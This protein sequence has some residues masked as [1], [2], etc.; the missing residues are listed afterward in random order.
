[1]L[2]IICE[3]SLI[4]LFCLR[5]KKPGAVSSQQA[6]QQRGIIEDW[7]AFDQGNRILRGK[8]KAHSEGPRIT[9]IVH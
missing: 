5:T 1:M 7:E 8:V 3:N 9:G 6:H 2:L 4:R